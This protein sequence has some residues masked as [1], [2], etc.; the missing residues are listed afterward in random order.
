MQAVRDAAPFPPLPLGAPNPVEVLFRFS[1]NVP[2]EG[3][4][5]DYT[6]AIIKD[7]RNALAFKNRGIIHN[8]L[9]EYRQ[10]IDDLSLSI[11][12]NSKDAHTYD[13]RAKSYRAIG[14]YK[15]ASDDEKEAGNLDIEEMQSEPQQ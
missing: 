10:A 12:L 6:K 2:L 15:G 1:N 8:Q 11:Q 5:E 14:R 7:R 4:L 3:S 9:G 13:E